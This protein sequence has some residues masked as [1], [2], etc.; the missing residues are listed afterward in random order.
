MTQDI[1]SRFIS[2]KSRNGATFLGQRSGS[3][4]ETDFTETWEQT[5]GETTK[6]IPAAYISRERLD[7]LQKVYQSYF[8]SQTDK[9]SISYLGKL[10]KLIVDARK[11]V[12]EGQNGFLVRLVKQS[13][14]YFIRAFEV[15]LKIDLED[16]TDSKSLDLENMFAE[17]VEKE[18]SVKMSYIAASKPVSGNGSGSVKQNTSEV[19]GPN[20]TD[21]YKNIGRPV[22]GVKSVVVKPKK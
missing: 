2:L 19:K 7:S 4:S 14:G 5:Y 17:M 13:N 11:P 21:R 1:T 20:P 8:S 16:K 10:K 6:K 9:K 3:E 15:D 18:S 22:A 12:Y